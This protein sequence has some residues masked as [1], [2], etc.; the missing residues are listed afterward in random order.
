MYYSKY[1]E[2][3]VEAESAS[4]IYCP[5][6]G[7]KEVSSTQIRSSAKKRLSVLGNAIASTLRDCGLDA[8][9]VTD[10]GYLYF[11]YENSDIGIFLTAY[12]NSAAYLGVYPGNNNNGVI[13][14]GS[15]MLANQFN[16]VGFSDYSINTEVYYKFCVT[17]IGDTSSMF[18]IYIGEYTSPTS[19][20]NTIGTFFF[21]KDKRDDSDIFGVQDGRPNTYGAIWLKFS[22]YTYVVDSSKMPP[23]NKLTIKDNW[24]V[25]IE[26]YIPSAAFIA[27]DNVYIDPGISSGFY[28]IDGDIYFCYSP[29]FIKCTTEVTPTPANIEE[30]N[31]G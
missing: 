25:L 21:G 20:S 23:A 15:Y 12:S 29:F 27:M 26:Q 1:F 13:Q 10:T 18:T 22:D 28:E 19:T 31:N 24:I 7:T 30:N 17:V 2:G 8:R 3:S 5:V 11:D 4:M 16:N 14:Q 9:Y 6:A